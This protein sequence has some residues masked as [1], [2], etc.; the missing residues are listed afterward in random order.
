MRA[1]AL[2][3]TAA[4]AALLVFVALHDCPKPPTPPRVA[5]ADSAAVYRARVAD[6]RLDSS[7]RADMLAQSLQEATKAG[8]RARWL[9]VRLDSIRAALGGPH[10]VDT[11]VETDTACPDAAPAI[12]ALDRCQSGLAIARQQI[13]VDSLDLIGA[14]SEAA[15]EVEQ[16]Q[17]Q[18][19]TARILWGAGGAMVGLLLGIFAKY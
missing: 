10:G 17:E 16:V 13:R 15:F 4:F 7:I 5:V 2:A 8:Q 14:R 9:R 6:L 3:I 19:K 11:V 12:I 18:H 1:Y